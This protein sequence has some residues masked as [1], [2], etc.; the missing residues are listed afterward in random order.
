MRP[1]KAFINLDALR[2]N[3]EVAAGHAPASKNVA[4]IKANAYGH[5]LVEAGFAL[6]SRADALAVATIDEAL[7]LRSNGVAG[8]LLVLQGVTGRDD[9]QEAV[10]GNLWLMLHDR[11]QV[12][13]VLSMPGDDSITAWL[14]IDSGMHRLGIPL[15]EAEDACA[16]LLASPKISQPP[17]LATHFACADELDSPV[18]PRQIERFLSFA[19]TQGLP[20]SMANS[21]GILH[22]PASRADWNRPGI[23]LY[24]CDPRNTFTAGVAGLRP[25]M[26]LRSEIMAIRRVETGGGVGYGQRWKATAPSRIATVS[27]GYGD[28]YPRH[29]PDGTPVLV[30]GKRAALAG[31]VSMDMITVDITGREDVKVGDPVE[32]WGENLLVNEVAAHAGTIGYE[33]L[34]GMTRRVPRIFS[35]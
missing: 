9:V 25:V 4:V 11:G 28:G 30:K 18:T 20:L 29:A 17:V 6:Q 32:L 3:L 24:G 2:H 1:T 34:A 8:P 7:E 10:A 22:W 14:K 23:M 27:A 21:A 33:L 26:S 16:A 15:A 12:E 19:R 35:G 5:G 13:K 31:T